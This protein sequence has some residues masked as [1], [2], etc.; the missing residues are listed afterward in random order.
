MKIVLIRPKYNSHIITPPLGLGY[1]SAYLKK[2][3]VETII[4]DALRDSK[5]Q[6]S[7]CA[8]VDKIKPDFVGITCLTAFYKETVCLAKELKNK[9]YKVGIGGVHPTFLPYQT[10]VDSQVDF[11]FCGEGE[12]AFSKLA[13]N[14]FV[15]NGIQGVYSLENLKSENDSIINGEIVID[16]DELPFPNWEQINPN[17]YPRAPHGA[18][19]KNFPIGVVMTSRGCTYECTF[20]ASPGFYGRRIRFRSPE[21]VVAEIELLVKKYGVKEIHFED[22]NLTLVRDKVEN[23]CRLL[24][25]KKINITWACPNGIR[26]DKVD[27]DLIRLMKESGCYYFSYGI[28]SANPQILENIK[29]REKISDIEKAI[30]IASEE[31]IDCQGF[32]IFGLP[33]E[34]QETIRESI[35]FAKNSKLSRAQF[36]I[37]DVLPGSALWTDLKGKFVPNWQKNSYKEPEW[38]PQGIPKDLLLKAQSTAFR[39]FYFRLKIIFRLLRLVNYNQIKFILK[40][41]FEYRII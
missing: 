25:K 19:V 12:I 23:L 7:V 28:E 27:Q 8:E 41:L 29:K 6:T 35:D 22:D 31:G 38:I 16:L 13:K 36:L 40:R 3:G 20:C 21:N 10:L 37:L 26:A 32:F 39:E 1:L 17:S 24:I 11:V 34:T 9:G 2:A 5:I 14:N 15:N 18:L 33:G 4:I 30:T